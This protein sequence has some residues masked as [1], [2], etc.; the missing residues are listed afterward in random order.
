[1]SSII[2]T[3]TCEN[4]GAYGTF[5]Q[6]IEGEWDY[7]FMVAYNTIWFVNTNGI[8]PT[9]HHEG[10]EKWNDEVVNTW[11]SSP[12]P[13]AMAN[14]TIPPTNPYTAF[15]TLGATEATIA[16]RLI[17]A[18]EAAWAYEQGELGFSPMVATLNVG[19]NANLFDNLY[20]GVDGNVALTSAF[21]G[22]C[23]QY[24]AG[25]N[26][27]RSQRDRVIDSIFE[28]DPDFNFN[29]Y[30]ASPYIRYVLTGKLKEWIDAGYITGFDDIV[31]WIDDTY[32]EFSAIYTDWTVQIGDG[33]A[34]KIGLVWNSPGLEENEE[35]NTGNA[36]VKVAV[37]SGQGPQTIGIY[38]FDNHHITLSWLSVAQLAGL[39]GVRKVLSNLTENLGYIQLTFFVEYTGTAA[40]AQTSTCYATI[41]Y[42]GAVGSYGVME[43]TDGSSVEIVNGGDPDEDYIDFI[44]DI[45]N[46]PEPEIPPSGGYSG[47]GVLTKTYVMDISKLQALG[48]FLWQRDFFDMIQPN[49]NAPLDNVIS[50]KAFPFSISGGANEE[51]VLGNVGTAIQAPPVP[52]TYNCRKTVG[53][54]TIPRGYGADLN[55]LNTASFTTLM[56]FLPYAGFFQLDASLF[57]DKTLKV[58][59]IVDI[60]HGDCKY[61]VYANGVAISDYNGVIGTDI[62]LASTNRA[63][64]EAGIISNIGGA[65]LSAA[66]GNLGGYM[67]NLLSAATAQF[68]TET[69]GTSSPTCNNFETHSVYVT[70]ETPEVQIPARYNHTHGRPCNLTKTLSGLT[71]FT[72]CDDVDVSG[73]S[74]ATREELE[75]IKDAL[76]TGVYL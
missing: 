45:D 7:A 29:D 55:Y 34:P 13:T 62:A 27:R 6:T 63:Q 4:L 16:P 58:D 2:L 54:I 67:N 24:D 17:Q 18:V 36:R 31:D 12:V 21:I 57:L 25:T 47:I 64:V 68:R 61:L 1:M 23:V 51:I 49:N 33:K 35:Y 50:C 74:G 11:S 53:S 70:L 15:S 14:A 59:I 40:V 3:E 72:I 37:Q 69:K 46:I 56:I 73:I 30:A 52:A 32:G 41:D 65:I 42:N 9:V 71:G 39:A 20:M 8:A 66:A 5:T 38:A 10:V 19:T 28:V 22:A 26:A 76:E 43:P 44:D 48:R 75:M 60:I